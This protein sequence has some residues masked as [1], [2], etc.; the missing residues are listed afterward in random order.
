MILCTLGT[1]VLELEKAKM[2]PPVTI[3]VGEVV[4][5]SLSP[6]ER[7]GVRESGQ[8]RNDSWFTRRPLFGKRILLTRP[9]DRRDSL[10][11]PLTELGAECL[12]QPAIEI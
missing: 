11:D 6:G 1:V 8:A 9:I 10:L 5:A 4:S 12:L 2:R 3:I 7:A